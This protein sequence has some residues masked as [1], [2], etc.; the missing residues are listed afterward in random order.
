VSGVVSS[1]QALVG[2]VEM[3]LTQLASPTPPPTS[4]T[5]KGKKKKQKAAAAVTVKG[6]LPHVHLGDHASV[7]GA[8]LAAALAPGTA[9]EE[10]VVLEVDKMG[11]PTVSIKPL[12]LTAVAAA[13]AK[14]GSTAATGASAAAGDEREALI[15]KSA[16][17][18][19]PGDLLAG[20]VSRVESFGVFVK[21]LGRF[22]ALCPRSMAADR[23]VEDPSGMF[24]EGDSVR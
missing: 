20:F 3:D 15:P 8:P 21:F 18:V 14:R 16:E 7:C 1:T 6:A 12:L 5:K 19:S 11:V 17:D 22:S 4:A 24:T 9:V 2:A 10:L 23:V 13:A